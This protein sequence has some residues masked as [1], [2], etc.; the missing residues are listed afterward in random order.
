MAGIIEIWR[1]NHGLNLPVRFTV[2]QQPALE[3]GE[4]ITD[5]PVVTKI[6]CFETG[7]ISGKRLNEPVFRICFDEAAVQRFVKASDV[8]EV[9]Y[10]VAKPQEA[11]IPDLEE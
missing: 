10:E 2:D 1:K 4:V 6:D 7:S 11:K 9:A 8:V 5:S 3:S